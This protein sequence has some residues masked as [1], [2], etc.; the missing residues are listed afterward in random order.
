MA[1]KVKNEHPLSHAGRLARL[2]ETKHGELCQAMHDAR[3]HADIINDHGFP[4]TYRRGSV[5][6][7]PQLH[8]A[9]GRLA[10]EA[11]PSA[12]RECWR[13]SQSMMAMFTGR[14]FQAKVLDAVESAWPAM[15][16]LQAFFDKKG[17]ALIRP[18]VPDYHKAGLKERARKLLLRDPSVKK[19]LESSAG[20]AQ[21]DRAFRR[22]LETLQL[23][24]LPKA[25]PGP[26]TKSKPSR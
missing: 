4:E 24:K 17:R 18:T 26:R 3:V 13:K 16:P 6:A 10:M 5:E 22:A 8:E 14:S 2:W 19:L 23:D 20:P 1:R 15:S 21:F 7:L 25:K 9:I 12:F 11:G